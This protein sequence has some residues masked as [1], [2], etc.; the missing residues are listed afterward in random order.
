MLRE[1]RQGPC[2]YELPDGTK[3]LIEWQHLPKTNQPS[4]LKIAKET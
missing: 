4:T 1:D 3:V 2:V